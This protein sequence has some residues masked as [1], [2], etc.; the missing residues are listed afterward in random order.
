MATY[1]TIAYSPAGPGPAD[2]Q[3][4]FPSSWDDGVWKYA[5]LTWAPISHAGTRWDTREE[6]QAD[7]YTLLSF[8]GNTTPTILELMEYLDSRV[9]RH[10][11][12]ETDGW[13]RRLLRVPNSQWEA[14][15]GR[16]EFCTPDIVATFDREERM[17]KI[18]ETQQDAVETHLRL[19]ASASVARG[20]ETTFLPSCKRSMCTAHPQ[21]S[22]GSHC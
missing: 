6:M 4:D 19:T 2:R 12:G 20:Y 9:Q 7:R 22:F 18:E 21:G 8:P 17:E 1:N 16:W 3:G 5:Q 14:P 15:V 10:K 11:N 13:V